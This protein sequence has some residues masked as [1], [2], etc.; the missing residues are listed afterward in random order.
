M[1][2]VVV[3]AAGES[4]PSWEQRVLERTGGHCANCGGEDRVRVRMIIPPE[5]G[6][7]RVETNGVALCRPCE[8]AS[9]SM[10]SGS[11]DRR[12][13]NFWVSRDLY[14][15][16]QGDTGFSSMGA[17]VRYLAAK[18]ITDEQRFDDLEQ[19]QDVGTDVKLNVWIEAD[20]YA[21]FKT[22]VDKRGMT[23]TD[24]FKAL[25]RVFQTETQ[26]KKSKG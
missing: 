13:V 20:R 5:A 19:H 23:V 8:L 10:R 26:D 18:Y 25:L 11:S 12:L 17:L 14:D 3:G 1:E 21:T 9:E 4:K 2:E 22:M 15:W 16:I 24:A 6:G 7:Q